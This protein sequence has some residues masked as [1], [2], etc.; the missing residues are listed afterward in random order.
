MSAEVKHVGTVELLIER[1]FAHP[2][3]VVFEAWLNP[4]ALARWMGPTDDIRISDIK[5]DAIEDG[6]YSMTFNDPDGTINRLKGVYQVIQRYTQL[7]FTWMWEQP[8]EGAE[9]ETLVTL[10]FTPTDTGTLL[11]LMHQRF[12]SEEV[13]DRHHWGWSGTLDKFERY[14]AELETLLSEGAKSN[15]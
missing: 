12:L 3:E 7:I 11:S 9:V 6:H 2:P 8:T 5:V 14:A 4:E 15:D 13:R 10:N 1:E